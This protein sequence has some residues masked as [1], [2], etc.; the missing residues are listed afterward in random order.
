ME[1][2]S[3]LTLQH[4]NH[5][6]TPAKIVEQNIA[7]SKKP[8]PGHGISVAEILHY[9]HVPLNHPTGTAKPEASKQATKTIFGARRRYVAHLLAG[10]LLHTPRR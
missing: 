3:I 8:I 6:Q 4:T 5:I 1:A 2:R 9:Q 7:L 10:L